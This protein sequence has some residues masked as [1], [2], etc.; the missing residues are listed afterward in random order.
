MQSSAATTACTRTIATT[1]A[2][3]EL[4]QALSPFRDGDSPGS[5]GRLHRRPTSRKCQFQQDVGR[6]YIWGV[7][8][9]ALGTQVAHGLCEPNC[10]A[11]P[12]HCLFYCPFTAFSL[13]LTVLLPPPPPEQVTETGSSI[14]LHSQQVELV[15]GPLIITLKE[16]PHV[17]GM[18]PWHLELIA[19]S[20]VAPPVNTAV[21]RL[22]NLSP[23]EST[24]VII[25]SHRLSLAVSCLS[26]RFYRHR[27]SL[28][29]HCLLPSALQPRAVLDRH[30]HRGHGG[31]RQGRRGHRAVL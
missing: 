28:W 5:Q 23:G 21:V 13:P 9:V 19:A 12:F 4:H 31:Q 18:S 14:I 20:Y 27:L 24:R 11:L 26:L 16:P 29:L 2:A 8:L 17:P 22:F 15:P 30:R 7:Q 6:L 25:G 3:A 10:K 1:S